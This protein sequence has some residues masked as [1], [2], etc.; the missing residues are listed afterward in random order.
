MSKIQHGA[1][2]DVPRMRADSYIRHAEETMLNDSRDFKTIEV[3]VS[4][5]CENPLQCFTNAS[6]RQLASCGSTHFRGH[7]EVVP[8][9]VPNPLIQ[10]GVRRR[11]QHVPSFCIS[12]AFESERAQDERP[13]LD[14]DGS[15]LDCGHHNFNFSCI[16]QVASEHS[17]AAALSARLW[18]VELRMCA[19]RSFGFPSSRGSNIF[20]TE[21]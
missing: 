5:F 4:Y 7:K 12:L 9:E 10:A 11:L 17:Q 2:L 14:E 15:N 6:V 16:S 18:N 19:I 21:A 3:C 8:T 13:I 20:I 1:L